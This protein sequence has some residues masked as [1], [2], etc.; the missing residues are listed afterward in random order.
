M[1]YG[2]FG[3]VVNLKPPGLLTCIGN[4]VW[5]FVL[6]WVPRIGKRQ[7][8]TGL[9]CWIQDFGLWMHVSASFLLGDWTAAVDFSFWSVAFKYSL[10]WLKNL[11][12]IF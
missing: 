11:K 10:Y 12:N 6:C 9:G 4:G 2:E 7:V 3:G 1:C 8:F 5:L